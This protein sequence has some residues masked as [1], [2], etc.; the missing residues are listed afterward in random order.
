MNKCAGVIIVA[1]ERKYLEKREEKRG[2]KSPN[3]LEK[4]TYTTPWNH[5]ESEIC[6]DDPG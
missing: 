1:Y 4:R 2:A 6:G 3:A 5:I